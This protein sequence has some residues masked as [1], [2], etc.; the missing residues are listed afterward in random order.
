MSNLCPKGPRGPMMTP[1]RRTS[2]KPIL[3][4]SQF[5]PSMTTPSFW[6]GRS[7]LPDQK[8]ALFLFALVGKGLLIIL[9]AVFNQT[10][11]GDGHFYLTGGDT[12]S[13][14][15]PIESLLRGEG[16]QPDL[17]MPGYGAAYWLLRLFL[18]PHW[19]L[20][21]LVVLQWLADA[22]TVFLLADMAWKIT[23]SRQAH[24]WTFGIALVAVYVTSFDQRILTETLTAFAI[25]AA[26][27]QVVAYAGNARSGNLFVAGAMITWAGFM[28]PVYFPLVPL[29]ALVLLFSQMHQLRKGLFQVGIFILPVLLCDGAWIVR[30]FRVHNAFR[31]LTASGTTFSKGIK[32][33][34][35]MPIIELMQAMG[36]NYVWWDAS[37]DIRWFNIREDGPTATFVQDHMQPLPQRLFT[38]D[39]N[40]DSLRLIGADVTNWYNAKDS[41]ERTLLH[42]R[43]TSRCNRYKASFITHHPFQYH[44][45]APLNLFSTFVLDSGTATLMA[46]P[47]PQLP[48]WQKGIKLFYSGLYLVVMLAGIMGAFIALFNRSF[49]GI[50]R[51]IPLAFL[52]G[53]FVFP[54][55]MRLCENRYLVVVYPLAIFFSVWLAL[56][57]MNR[58][59]GKKALRLCNPSR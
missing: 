11:Q 38:A 20:V 9:L 14:L 42:D 28:R 25:V 51:T 49:N 3:A 39:Y 35:K 5:R 57:L 7:F 30:N 8:W 16:Y 18:S 48:W 33:S 37:A 53:V 44:V 32:E 46:Q 1:E 21:S 13:Y 41:A 31:P 24:T 2:R 34:I 56:N 12:S 22:A 47:W 54:F 4:R 29:I 27:H 59:S 26:L 55:V 10:L 17:R 45:A 40:M 6:S 23:R 15:L 36:R 19:A 43:I 52:Y 50:L 58:V